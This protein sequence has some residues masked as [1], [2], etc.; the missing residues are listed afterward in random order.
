MKPL[1]SYALVIAL[2]SLAAPRVASAQE[3]R[4]QSIADQQAE[5]AKQLHPYEPSAGEEIALRLKKALIDDPNGFYPWFGSVYSGGGFTLGAGYR[6]F[7]GDRSFWDA[8][9][10]YSVK[11]YKLFELASTSL[12]LA[13]DRVNVQ[14]VGGWRD[15]TQVAFYGVGNETSPDAKS[16]FRIKQVYAGALAHIREPRKLFADVGGQYEDYSLESGTGSSPSIEQGFTPATAPGLGANP[17][18]FHLTL[19]GGLDTRAAPGYARRGGMYAL[20]YDN[21][22]DVD[23]TYSFDT[24]QAE[25]VQHL[26]ILRENWVVSLHGMVKTTLD[27]NDT[28]PYFLLPSLGSGS[29]LRGYPSWRF[30]D[31]HSL[32]MSGEWRWIPSR[33]ALD[34]AF[35]YDAGK[36]TSRREDLS[37]DGLKTDFGVGVRFHSPVA[38]PLRID[39]AKGSEGVNIVFSGGAAF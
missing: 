29:T 4:A 19:A 39:I 17:A 23:S 33:M 35:F 6:R 27:D 31:R 8:R 22:A 25:A 10:M 28:V 5:K 34:M 11:S 3:T 9:G 38:T 32:L 36:V 15:A 30:R 7:Y 13:H 1:C 20:V 14:A 24:L 12:G 2:I 18:Y 37:F 21:F 26:P 16:N